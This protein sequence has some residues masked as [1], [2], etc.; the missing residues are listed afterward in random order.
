MKQRTWLLIFA[1]LAAVLFG[2]WAA[3]RKSGGVYAAV[4]QDGRQIAVLD[5]SRDTHMSVSGPIGTN[6]IVVTGGAVSVVH[7]DC[8]DQICVK[9]GPL[10]EHGG[11]IVCL[12]NRLSIEWLEA[13]PKV[14]AV[15][16]GGG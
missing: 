14:D 2:L 10:S 15:S 8:R 13:S 5:L 9:H 7:A 6:E 3:S 12:P 16:G 1:A 11:P 4:Y